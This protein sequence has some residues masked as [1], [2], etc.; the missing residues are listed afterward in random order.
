MTSRIQSKFTNMFDQFYERA[1][2]RD[3]LRGL[4]DE[5]IIKEIM[6]SPQKIKRQSRQLVKF[7]R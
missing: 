4:T 6:A 2:Y 3:R 1:S 7:L 5:E